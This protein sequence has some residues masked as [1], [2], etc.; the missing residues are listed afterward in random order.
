MIPKLN[1]L[2]KYD[3]I[4][5]STG[6]ECRFRAYTVKEEKV[7]L[8]AFEGQDN[9]QSLKAIFETVAACCDDTLTMKDLTLYDIQFLFSKIRARSVGE[10]SD[11]T[12]KCSECQAEN[13]VEID[14]DGIKMERAEKTT[15]RIKISDNISIQLKHPSFFDIMSS[16]EVTDDKNISDILISL[17]V[18]SLETIYTADERVNVKEEPREAAVE[19]IESM[20]RVQFEK[21]IEF[22]GTIPKLAYVADFECVK[23]KHPNHFEIKDNADFF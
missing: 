23:C 22:I 17:A 10:T 14:V 16:K 12:I 11:L 21:I 8:L 18:D 19:F 7:L 13:I 15:A 5:P 1:D 2:P 6:K 4:V 20:S 9:K 3:L